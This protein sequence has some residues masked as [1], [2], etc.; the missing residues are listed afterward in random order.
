MLGCQNLIHAMYA[1]FSAVC[2]AS[3]VVWWVEEKSLE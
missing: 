3:G 1:F 2:V